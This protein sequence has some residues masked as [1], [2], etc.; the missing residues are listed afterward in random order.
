MTAHALAEIDRFKIV[1][2]PTGRVYLGYDQEWYGTAWQRRAGCGPT[3]ACNLL[4]YLMPSLGPAARK[5]P[6][7]R[8]EAPAFME[9][10]WR[11]VTPT[12]H[13]VNTTSLFATSVLA[14]AQAQAWPLDCRVWDV[15][16]ARAHRLPLDDLVHVLDKALAQ[17]LP[18]AFLNLCNGEES[19]LDEW[20]WVTIIALADARPGAGLTVR[21]LDSGAVK[22]I[23]LARWYATTTRDGG[24]VVLAPRGPGGHV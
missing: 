3:T 18:V 8:S 21:L 23:D 22:Q 10:L 14:Y 6:D 17:D 5:L 16:A 2:Q 12:C 15:P 20:H 11:Y 1:D 24:F 7:R 9:E 13:G 4:R 19:L